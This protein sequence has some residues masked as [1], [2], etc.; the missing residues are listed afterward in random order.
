MLC[1][2]GLTACA[3]LYY[4]THAMQCMR[5][6]LCEAKLVDAGGGRVRV[7]VRTRV[8]CIELRCIASCC[9][10]LDRWDGSNPTYGYR[11]HVV[12]SRDGLESLFP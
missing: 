10:G 8:D 9:I 4:A 11:T 12:A 2:A 3:I 7:R 5:C 6:M 1:S